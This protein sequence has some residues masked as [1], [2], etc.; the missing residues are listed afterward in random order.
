MKKKTNWIHIEF[1]FKAPFWNR[2]NF[3]LS[4]QEQVAFENILSLILMKCIPH[5]K[6]KF[7]LYEPNPHCFLALE[8]KD[9]KLVNKIREQVEFIK[10]T[11]NSQIKF[12]S[13]IEIKENTTDGENKDGFIRVL[14]AMCDYQL[15][16]KDNSLSRIIHCMLDTAGLTRKEENALYALMNKHYR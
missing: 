6:R 16:Y 14:D 13:C 5:Y 3:M 9:H 8:L 2:S 15:Q 11:Y 4:Y 1:W 12:I 7:Y 10:A